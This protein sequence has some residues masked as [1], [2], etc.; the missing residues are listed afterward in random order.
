MNI[1]LP[2]ETSLD[3]YKNL[4]A[5]IS[6][7]A[8]EKNKLTKTELVFLAHFMNLGKGPGYYS[9]SPASKQAV[10]KSMGIT[11]SKQLMSFRL[12]AILHK[13]YLIK[14]EDN[15][16]AFAPHLA[17]LMKNKTVNVNLS[18]KSP[19][20]KDSSRNGNSGTSS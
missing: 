5:L 10:A 12:N 2:T 13:G 7:F 9:F 4:L 1:N 14:D 19:D 15:L 20:K 17:A 18:Y 6:C 11:Y 16:L 3:F 8:P